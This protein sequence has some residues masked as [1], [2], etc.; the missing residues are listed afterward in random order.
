MSCVGSPDRATA[1]TPSPTPRSRHSEDNRTPPA[2]AALPGTPRTRRRQGTSSAAAQRSPD[3]PPPLPASAAQHQIPHLEAS[4]LKG[5][6]HTY[7]RVVGGDWQG[8]WVVPLSAGPAITLRDRTATLR[9]GLHVGGC[10]G[11]GALAGR[12]A[13]CRCTPRQVTKVTWSPSSSTAG[14]IGVVQSDSAPVSWRRSA[15]ARRRWPS[16]PARRASVD[17]PGMAGLLRVRH[18][19]TDAGVAFRA[20]RRFTRPSARGR[21][22]WLRGAATRRVTR[23]RRGPRGRPPAPR[24]CSP[25]PAPRGRLSGGLSR[26]GI[27]RA[28]PSWRY[29]FAEMRSGPQRGKPPGS[30][31][32]RTW[33]HPPMVQTSAKLGLRALAVT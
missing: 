11:S 15:S 31:I 4:A 24:Q 14:S 12:V 29:R 3:N 18:A 1:P 21:G 2:T 25:T 10:G 23:H 33:C 30:R 32:G 22:R 20:Q 13:G 17:W 9:E 5:I 16:T 7:V 28:D 27:D 8:R 6:R 19:V 26:T